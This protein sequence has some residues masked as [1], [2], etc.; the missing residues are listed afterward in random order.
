M[1]Y[2]ADRVKDVTSSTGTGAITLAG[3]P[4]T[5]FRSFATGLGAVPV[6]TVYCIQGAT[7]EWEVGKGTFNGST[8]LTRDVVRA[9]SNANALVSFS[10]GSKDVFITANAEIIDNAS[11]G[12]QYANSRG[13]ALP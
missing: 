10:A 12:M 7:G 3:T 11:L 9:S 6:V 8:G 4:P 1:P 2:F 13:F 5:G